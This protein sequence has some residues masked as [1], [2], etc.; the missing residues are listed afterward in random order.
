[1]TVQGLVEWRGRPVNPKWH[2]GVRAALFLHVLVVLVNAANVANLMNL[3]SYLHGTMHMG[4]ASS[5]TTATNF[6][7]AMCMFSLVGAFISDSYIKRFHT[8]L[9]FGPLEVLGY[10]LLA[11]QAH[12]RSLHPPQCDINKEN[13][14]CVQVHGFN[15]VLLNIGLY[16]VTFGEGCLRACISSLGGDQFDDDDTIEQ[17]QKISF[18]NWYTFAISFGGFLGLIFVVWVEN[19]KGWDIGFALCALL[20]FTGLIVTACGF[21]FYRNQIPAGSPLTR[22]LQVFVAAYRKRNLSL[23]DYKESEEVANRNTPGMEVFSRTTGFK[24]LD[25]ATID[26]GEKGG[27][28]FCNTTQVEEIKIIL[29]MLPLFIS[30]TIGYLPF[31]LLMTFTVQQGGTMNTQ[32]GKIHIS[33]ASLFVIPITFQM[34]TL[35]IYDQVI[36]PLLRKLTGYPGGITHLQRVGIGFFFAAVATAVAALVETKRKKV[37]IEHGLIDSSTGI[38]M[39]VFWLGLQFFF[40]GIID[41][42]SFVGLLEFFYSEASTGMKSIGTS[43]FFCII[44]VAA[45]LSS[46]L[47]NVVNKVTRNGEGK[48]WLD[49]A[50]LNRSHLDRFYWLLSV[51][52]LLSFLNYAYWANKYV[53]RY[54]PGIVTEDVKR[55]PKRETDTI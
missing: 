24:F 51:I 11:I 45:W 39:S 3:V 55:S 48:G 15:F 2:G 50:N 13:N 53:C 52:G 16:T 14:N 41:V 4:I 12:Y 7:G 5:A 10:G 33:P 25:K 40:L 30:S 31:A 49:G 46:F 44:G 37:A 18:F 26:N 8:M 28:S 17:R 6:I 47:I 20:V 21:P 22:I 35:V 32:L 9:I 36:V 43:I 19:N 34:V 1:M 23:T 54:N 27:W 42:T 38:P 29:R